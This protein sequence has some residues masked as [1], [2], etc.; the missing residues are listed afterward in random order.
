MYLILKK[1]L[2]SHKTRVSFISS[3]SQIQF[4]E[5]KGKVNVLAK[6]KNHRL[7]EMI[8]LKVTF[9]SEGKWVFLISQ[10]TKRTV[11]I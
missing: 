5:P 3:V 2:I 10:S 7:L 8:S 6:D 4:C 1:R 9:K 11:S